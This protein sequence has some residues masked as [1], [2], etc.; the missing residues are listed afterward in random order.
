MLIPHNQTC[1]AP[2]CAIDR[3]FVRRGKNFSSLRAGTLPVMFGSSRM[4]SRAYRDPFAFAG[5]WTSR[6]LSPK[7]YDVAS[8]RDYGETG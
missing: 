4:P 5:L 2:P 7:I 3:T 8:S 1:L 6:M